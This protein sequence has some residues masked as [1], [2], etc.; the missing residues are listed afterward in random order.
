MAKRCETPI[1][2]SLKHVLDVLQ[3]KSETLAVNTIKG[4]VTAISRRH[5]LVHY[6]LLRLDLMLKRWIKSLDHSTDIPA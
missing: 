6:I 4:Y 5:A 2:M 3:A 1:C